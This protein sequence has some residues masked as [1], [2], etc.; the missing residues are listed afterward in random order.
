[1]GDCN[2]K[3]I[4]FVIHNLIDRVQ[5]FDF[6]E[7]THTCGSFLDRNIASYLHASPFPDRITYHHTDG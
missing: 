2:V 1:M 6:I 3:E 4:D 5:C 7:R